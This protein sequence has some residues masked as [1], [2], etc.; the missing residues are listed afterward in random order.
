MNKRKKIIWQIFPSYVLITVL[1]LVAVSWYAS[2]SLQQFYLDHQALD[3][4]ARALL[5]EKLVIGHLLPLDAAAIDSVCKA[6]GKSTE[7]R[8]TIILPSGL[9]VGDSIE[10]PEKMDNHANRPEIKQAYIGETGR[11]IR[12]S[13]TLR[14]EMMYVALPIADRRKR[15]AVVRASLPITFIE[16]ELNSIR[17]KIIIGGVIIAIIAAAISLA[18]SRRISRPLETMKKGADRYSQR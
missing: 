9:V 15:I 7:T 5:L 1:S 11:S 17:V 6:M 8:F 16:N 14:Q 18:I 3:L 12:Y 13:N 10:T 4:R 2:K